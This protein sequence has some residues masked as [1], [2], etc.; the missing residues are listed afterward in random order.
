MKRNAGHI[1]ATPSKRIYSS[2][3]ADYSL[4][5][6]ICELVDNAIDQW[7]RDGRSGSLAIKVAIELDQ[8]S[9]RVE[10]DSGGLEKAELNLLVT[11][12]GGAG[13]GGE[14]SIGIFGVGT[15]RAVVALA[16]QVQ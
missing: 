7:T 14:E 5:T 8:Q 12:G 6:G 15:R 2:I 9:I 1:D 10:D 13:T 3:I 4:R 16:Q 11:P